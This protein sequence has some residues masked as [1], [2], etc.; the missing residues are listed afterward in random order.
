MGGVRPDLSGWRP[1]KE[2][3]ETVHRAAADGAAHAA[4]CCVLLGAPRM[5]NTL[6]LASAIFA[7]AAFPLSAADVLKPSQPD[8]NFQPS[9]IEGKITF[10]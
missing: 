7:T 5:K 8:R 9:V 2:S 4:P 1:R 10:V 3:R 6:L